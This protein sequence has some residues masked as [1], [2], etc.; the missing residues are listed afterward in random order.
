M[1]ENH[2]ETS[3]AEEMYLITVAIAIEDGHGACV[4]MAHIADRLDVS[5]VSANQM[6]H[7]LQGRG[8]L[9]YTPYRGVSL[10]EEG[11][12][13]ASSI[14]RSRRL[15]GVF[16]SEQLGLSPA[17]ADE[18]ACELEHV[19]PAEVA[20]LLSGYLGDPSAGP[21]GKAIPRGGPTTPSVTAEPLSTIAAGKRGSI[22]SVSLPE[23][24]AKFVRDQELTPGTSIEV[25]GV[26]QHGDRLVSLDGMCLHLGTE[27]SDGILV[28]VV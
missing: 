4:S 8:F 26:G 27:L 24:L 20:D 17:R 21:Q 5:S 11:E 16:L 3:E 25:L 22:V 28:E 23:Q 12:T 1:A 9:E 18:V 15:W 2:V 10:T 13:V 6:I 7:K 14:L 19:T